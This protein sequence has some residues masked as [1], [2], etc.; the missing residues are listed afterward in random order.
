M[1]GERAVSFACTALSLCPLSGEWTKDSSVRNEDRLILYALRLDPKT[2]PDLQPSEAQLRGMDWEYVLERVQQER[3]ASILHQHLQD[4][5]GV[6][7]SVQAVLAEW[8]RGAG[9]LTTR[10]QTDLG[11]ILR[12]FTK[13]GIETIVLKGGVLV[14]T[15]YRN[16]ALR[17]MGDLDLLVREDA[18]PLADRSLRNLGWVSSENKGASAHHLVPYVR[19]GSRGAVELHRHVLP[20]PKFFEM[21]IEDL[22]RRACPERIAGEDTWMLCPED[23]LLHLCIHASCVGGGR[24]WIK[25]LAL[26]SAYDIALTVEQYRD[27]L[28]WRLFVARADAYGMANFVYW[29]LY[30]ARDI[31]GAPVPEDV[32]TD[33]NALCSDVQRRRLKAIL[34]DPVSRADTLELRVW[35]YGRKYTDRETMMNYLRTDIRL[36]ESASDMLALVWGPMSH[37]A[38][39]DRA[40]SICAGV[41]LGMVA[42]ARRNRTI[43]TCARTFYR[44]AQQGRLRPS[45][46]VR[47]SSFV[48]R[49]GDRSSF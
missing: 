47:P 41:F 48:R 33:L 4:R 6:P 1:L 5:T 46:V 43:S 29:A 13:D 14:E 35:P 34:R 30:S 23:L 9:Y 20:A 11:H 17:F 42:W 3:I 45:F 38:R 25:A 27:R 15:V 21:D 16:P 37:L 18:M 10:L 12:A 39:R 26:H 7:A 28:D 32:L 49:F 44:I 31:C 36:A 40:A 8:Y 19:E 24:K 22:W 2:R